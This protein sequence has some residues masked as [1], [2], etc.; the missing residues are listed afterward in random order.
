MLGCREP[1]RD[2]TSVDH[3]SAPRSAPIGSYHGVSLIDPVL[4]DCRPPASGHPAMRTVEEDLR[5]IRDRWRANIVRV[6]ITPANWYLDDLTQ[7]GSYR[8]MLDRVLDEAANLSLAV[9][10]DWHGFGNLEEDQLFTT[11]CG[12]GGSV[13]S[14][15]AGNQPSLTTTLIFW[16]EIASRYHDREQTL[17]YE[18]FNEPLFNDPASGLDWTLWASKAEAI[19]ETIRRYDPERPVMVAGVDWGYDLSGVRR[20]P[21]RDGHVIYVAHPYPG[22]ARES[23]RPGL[24]CIDVIDCWEQSFG[25]VADDYPVFVSEWGFGPEEPSCPDSPFRGGVSGYGG[26]LLDYLARKGIGWTAWSFSTTWKPALL[27]RWQDWRPS[28]PFG[29]FVIS[30][31][32]GDPPASRE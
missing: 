11:G 28:S 27:D 24:R 6:P 29:M 19:I 8:E 31:L 18:I 2:V 5:Q 20:R 26:P 32:G 1:H 12:G 3:F 13:G 10:I 9:I 14:F 21:I 25:R 23:C 16:N 4:Y 22:Y 30:A 15:A 7:R 17:Y